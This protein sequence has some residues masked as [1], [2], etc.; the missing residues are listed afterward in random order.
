MRIKT[1]ATA[2]L[3]LGAIF[4]G[5]CAQAIGGVK[6]GIQTDTEFNELFLE[7]VQQAIRLA[8]AGNDPLALK[9]WTYLEKFTIENAPNAENPA[10]EVVGVLSGY[11]RARNVRRNVIE[12]KI[13]DQFRLECGPMLTDTMGA[14]GRIGIRLVL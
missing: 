4:L 3:L 2:G 6:F 1:L 12:V 14:L 13:S 8:E 10:G 9:C 7:D 11:Q 5:G